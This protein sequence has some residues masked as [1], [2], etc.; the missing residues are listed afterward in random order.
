VVVLD[1]ATGKQKGSLGL[2]T[3][4][5]LDVNGVVAHAGKVYFGNDNDEFLCYEAASQQL[6]WRLPV[7][8][9]I[10]HAP[11][12]VKRKGG[13]VAVV[14]ATEIGEVRAVHPQTGETLWVYYAPGFDG[15]KP[16]KERWIFRVA[17]AASAGHRCFDPPVLRDINRDGVTDLVYKLDNDV[18]CISGQ[19]G[20]PITH[21]SL[22]DGY[23]GYGQ[24]LILEHEGGWMLVVNEF[25]PSRLRRYLLPSGRQL[26]EVPL[27]FSFHLPKFDPPT[28]GEELIFPGEKYYFKVRN[29][30][31]ALVVDRVGGGNNGLMEFSYGAKRLARW[32]GKEVL[33]SIK[34]RANATRTGLLMISD[35]VTAEV[36]Q[37]YQ[38][39]TFSESRP[40]LLD[41]DG[42]GRL[43]LLFGCEDG[44]TYCHSIPQ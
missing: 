23:F 16:G 34:E 8:A 13:D 32:R 18:V 44:K 21:I 29:G 28:T 39:P 6:L 30:E 20:K 2:D 9:D 11:T 24:P 42:D 15:W 43:E 1:A 17:A 27:D 25:H 26:P 7:S 41:V 3:W 22:P 19:T 31:P 36:L 10:E 37:V 38:L 12:L 5:D 35:P 4:G 14:L 40:H 33:F